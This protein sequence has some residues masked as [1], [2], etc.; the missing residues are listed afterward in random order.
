MKTVGR[1]SVRA[2]REVKGAARVKVVGWM[3]DNGDNVGERPRCGAS[4]EAGLWF[5]SLGVTVMGM[6]W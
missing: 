5:L 2:G 6:G 3:G 1:N 4:R